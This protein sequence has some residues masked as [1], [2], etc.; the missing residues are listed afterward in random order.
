V[1]A[2]FPIAQRGEKILFCEPSCLSVFKDDA[3]ALLRGD[4]QKQAQTVADACMLF[5]EFASK[6]DLPLKP[7]PTRILVHGHCHQKSLGLLPATMALLNQ[8]P[9]AQVVDLDAGCCGMAGSFGYSKEHYEI[10]EAIANRR[11]L[12]EAQKMG[13]GDALVAPGT[14]CR[15]QVAE[16]NGAKAQHPA[17]L[18]RGLLK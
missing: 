15:H 3:P 8:I 7:G 13:P 16:L 17:V 12:R 2:L 6:L 11:L 14:S 9:A 10:S 4:E 1:E 18:I 5:D